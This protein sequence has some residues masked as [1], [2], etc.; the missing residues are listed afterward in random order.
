MPSLVLIGPA[1]QPAIGN[2]QI[3]RRNTFYY[4]DMVIIGNLG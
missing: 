1:G 3:N 2:I 4:V